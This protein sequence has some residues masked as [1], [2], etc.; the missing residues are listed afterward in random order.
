MVHGGADPG[1]RV[2]RYK[3][4]RRGQKNDE[5]QDAERRR[6]QAR[7]VSAWVVERFEDYD[8]D[9]LLQKFS[10]GRTKGRSWYWSL[11]VGNESSTPVYDL[12]ARVFHVDNTENT[13]DVLKLAQALPRRETVVDLDPERDSEL[14]KIVGRHLLFADDHEDEDE[15]SRSRFEVSASDLLVELTFRDANNVSW[16]RSARGVLEEVKPS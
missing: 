5:D 6:A 4:F 3:A 2:L 11:V 9:P 8:L 12:T 7:D 16:K 14:S 10:M 1:G 13:L 15:D